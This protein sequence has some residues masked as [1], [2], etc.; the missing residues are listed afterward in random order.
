MLDQQFMSFL[1][2]FEMFQLSHKDS[3]VFHD[4]ISLCFNRSYGK[5]LCGPL[6]TAIAMAKKVT[7]TVMQDSF[8]NQYLIVS[9]A[10]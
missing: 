4:A 2:G 3:G 5:V 7:L 1:P 8:W 10:A 6:Y 9:L